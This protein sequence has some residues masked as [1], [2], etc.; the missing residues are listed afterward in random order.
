MKGLE[1]LR[2]FER[3]R[4][5]DAEQ[6]DATTLALRLYDHLVAT[7]H[8]HDVIERTLFKWIAQQGL[9]GAQA[10]AIAQ[11]A[12]IHL[13]APQAS[14]RP[15]VNLRARGGLEE[16]APTMPP[17]R[18]WRPIERFHALHALAG[19]TRSEIAFSE[20][21]HL[22]V[23]REAM[24]D[25]APR[26]PYR[27]PTLEGVKAPMPGVYALQMSARSEADSAR[28]RTME[29]EPGS[30]LAALGAGRPLPLA[31]RAELTPRLA[32]LG[33]LLDLSE[34][35]I[36]DDE[37]AATICS[38][39]GAE[40]F[41]VGDHVV[42]GRP[43]G[44]ERADLALL[45]HELTHVWQQ[46]RGVVAPGVEGSAALESEARAVERT[47]TAG[48]TDDDPGRA[49]E[50]SRLVHSFSRELG[51][52]PARVEVHA[53]EAAREETADRGL[54]GLMR[55]G[56]VYLDPDTYDPSVPDG[57]AL[58]AHELVHVAQR[59]QQRRGAN[60]VSDSAEA[61][62]EAHELAGQ[63]ALGQA[64]TP[65][66]VGLPGH[67]DAACGPQ[68]MAERETPPG[69][70]PR[71]ETEPRPEPEPEP[72]PTTQTVRVPPVYR[73]EQNQIVIPTIH[74]RVDKDEIT[75]T[76]PD[77]RPIMRHLAETLKTYPEIT[78]IRI[79]GFTSTTGTEEHNRALSQRRADKTRAWLLG[80]EKVAGVAMDT[81]GWG[82]AAD[83]LKIKTADEVEEDANRRTEITI[84]EVDGRPAP[85][86]WQPTRMRL[87]A[88]G[89]TII[90]HLD[91]EGRVVREEVIPDSADGGSSATGRGDD[92]APQGAPA[93]S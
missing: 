33:V 56:K 32:T 60:T 59:D 38:E 34:I 35:R 69:R 62:L 47:V 90:R 92:G 42:L 49:R 91:A 46:A 83:R 48:I 51:L 39:L 61:E 4:R 66:T 24:P 18:P 86:N 21:R 84:V 41:A 5:R 87:V 40:A 13:V 1:H 52:D 64:L 81:K 88:S 12:H 36:H 63:A 43:L 19:R 74:Y 27:S 55:E 6:A 54:L 80:K 73:I 7:G 25:I 67:V 9:N 11:R 14:G 72:S 53:D 71:R 82:E 23:M 85:A 37:Q 28:A 16:A 10:H 50:T 44:R 78:K 3:L 20:V 70:N 30:V 68:A 89:Q 2:R 76:T 57:R 75:E 79:E 65:P 22:E 29:L 58:L 77:A 45:A 15:V 17:A 8:A 93:A 26:S 31:M